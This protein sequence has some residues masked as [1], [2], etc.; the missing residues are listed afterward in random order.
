MQLLSRNEA[1]QS[2]RLF[3]FTGKPCLRGHVV[4]RRV[5]NYCCVQC[6]AEKSARYYRESTEKALAAQ[7]KWRDKN[8]VQLANRQKRYRTENAEKIAESLRQWRE[9]NKD[10]VADTK[11]QWVENNRGKKNASLSKRHA[12][13]LN[14]SPIW[15]SED[16]LWVIEEAYNL[17]KIRQQATGIVWHVDHIV[18]L[19]GKSV[20]GLHVPWNLQ[21]IPA[22]ENMSKGNRFQ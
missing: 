6:E 20:S 13:K 4:E 15:L 19:Q 17:A 10:R 2:G 14:R 16:D 3:Y 12:A 21:V 9:V 7:K 22:V 5:A 18:P 11:K 8:K 1:I